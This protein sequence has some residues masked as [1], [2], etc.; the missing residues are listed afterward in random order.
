MQ[1]AATEPH[2]P[3][4]LKCV[5]GELRLQVDSWDTL[6]FTLVPIMRL[7]SVHLTTSA[8][9]FFLTTLL[10]LEGQRSSHVVIL[11]MLN[12]HHAFIIFLHSYYSHQCSS[13]FFFEDR[14]A[15][16]FNDMFAFYVLVENASRHVKDFTKKG[17]ASQTTSAVCLS[18]CA[19]NVSLWPFALLL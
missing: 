15:S 2:R 19:L 14:R 1:Q 13:P 9:I 5:L 11:K 17:H 4:V 8:Q 3:L 6:L 10:P 16:Y 12:L 18:E 7:Q